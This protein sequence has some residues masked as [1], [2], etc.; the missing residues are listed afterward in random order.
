MGPPASG[1]RVKPCDSGD[2][3]RSCV[4]PGEIA[5]GTARTGT[6]GSVKIE[7]IA[8]PDLSINPTNE[9]T[10]VYSVDVDVTDGNGETRSDD[11]KVRVG[12]T[13]LQA[14]LTAEPW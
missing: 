7:F 11:R 4:I 5:N 9:P 13:A 6:D 10:F 2:D 14:A 1:V 12:Y 8:K 3:A